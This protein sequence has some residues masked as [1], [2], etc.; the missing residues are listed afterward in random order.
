LFILQ[1][2]YKNAFIYRNSALRTPL[3]CAAAQGYIKTVK[4]LA[5]SDAMIDATDKVDVIKII[6]LYSIMAL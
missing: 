1:C 5:E 6:L 2:T 3:A 4:V